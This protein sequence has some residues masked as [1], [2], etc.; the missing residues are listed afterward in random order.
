[1]IW[2][3]AGNFEVEADLCSPLPPPPAIVFVL[4]RK[5]DWTMLKVFPG[6]KF[7]YAPQILRNFY[8]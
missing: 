1:M 7:G 8:K 6:N 3:G 5:I 2:E 4:K